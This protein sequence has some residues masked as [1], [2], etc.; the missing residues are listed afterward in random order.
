MPSINW[1]TYFFDF[2]KGNSV[3]LPSTVYFH[4]EQDIVNIAE[5]IEYWVNIINKLD[6]SKIEIAIDRICSAIGKREDPRDSLIDAVM[7]WENMFGTH[8]EVT[9]RVCTAISKLLKNSYEERVVAKKRLTQLYAKRS[10]LVHGDTVKKED[11][12]ESSKEAV[13]TAL[14]SLSKLLDKGD[15]YLQL[16]SEKRSDRIICE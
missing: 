14:E 12:K 3:S 11:I 1:N 15:E 16:A 6:L 9:Y 8:D 13:K 2:L 7:S 4:D 5:K 10:R